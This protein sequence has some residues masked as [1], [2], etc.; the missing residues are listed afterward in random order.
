M[1]CVAVCSAAKDMSS[2]TQ[3]EKKKKKILDI[4]TS[5]QV[6]F[7]PKLQKVFRAFGKSELRARDCGPVNGQKINKKMSIF[8]GGTKAR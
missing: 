4:L 7:V 8:A 3:G 1:Y 5:V 6:K 2:H